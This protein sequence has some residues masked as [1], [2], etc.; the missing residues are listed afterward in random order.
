MDN[1]EET[2]T[3][4]ETA[5]FGAGC[6]WCVEAVFNALKGVQKVTS[7]YMGGQNENPTYQQVC[8]GTTGHAEVVQVVFD[9]AQ[10]T[11]TDLLEAFFASHDPTT[12]NRQGADKGTQYRSGIFYHSETQKQQALAYKSELSA[13]GHFDKPIV[14]EVSPA[15]AFYPAEAYH[16]NYYARQP[17]A[18]YCQ[19]VIRPKLDKFTRLFKD[20]LKAAQA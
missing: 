2:P 4:L 20:R 18:P 8:T 15:T 19:F 11:F 7:G 14:T 17:E 1:Q 3:G 16:D 5:T 6:F 13:S 10:I 12:L 9:P